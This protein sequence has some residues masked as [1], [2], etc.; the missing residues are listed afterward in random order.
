MS[1][2]TIFTEKA[3][4]PI[5]P[6]SQAVAAGNMVFVSGQIGI[7]PR[8]G[9]LVEGGVREQARQALLNLKAILEA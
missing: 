6:Y 9:R 5:G 2:K 4:K 7:D 3:P 8:S 1:V